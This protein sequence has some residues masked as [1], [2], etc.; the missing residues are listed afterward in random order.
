MATNRFHGMHFTNGDYLVGE[1]QGG[2]VFTALYATGNIRND[3][4]ISTLLSYL[5]WIWE[6]QLIQ[7]H[8][9]KLGG[10]WFFSLPDL[11]S[12][13]LLDEGH[14][15]SSCLF[16]HSP[17]IRRSSPAIGTSLRPRNL[18]LGVDGPCFLDSPAFLYHPSNGTYGYS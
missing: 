11:F 17:E 9:F 10:F 13:P 2:T 14:C 1:F 16:I 4:Q 18:Y 7:R 5:V 15:E 12:R 3:D 8:S 6:I